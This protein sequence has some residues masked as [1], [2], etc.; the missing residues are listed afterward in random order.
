MKITKT[1][2][3]AAVSLALVL[4]QSTPQTTHLVGHWFKDD[5][6]KLHCKWFD[7]PIASH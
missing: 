4:P 3:A 1:Q 7:E 2:K 5:N 6:G